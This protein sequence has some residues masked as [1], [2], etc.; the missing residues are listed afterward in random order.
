MQIL[1]MIIHR[2]SDRWDEKS[3]DIVATDILKL[4]EEILGTRMMAEYISKRPNEGYTVRYLDDLAPKIE[5]E[6]YENQVN[7]NEKI[8]KQIVYEA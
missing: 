5:N 7:E 2:I 1:E 6:M 3:Q 8:I 4:I